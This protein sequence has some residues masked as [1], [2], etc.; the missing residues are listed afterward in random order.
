[1]I[2]KW[3]KGDVFVMEG[4]GASHFADAQ[5]WP[6]KTY[7]PGEGRGPIGKVVVTARGASLSPSP[8]GAPAFVGVVT[9]AGVVSFAGEVSFG[10]GA[11]FA[12]TASFA[13]GVFDMLG[14]GA[15]TLSGSCANRS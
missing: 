8:D 2:D 6:A 4:S 15:H 1:M 9:L 14:Y 12:Q 5:E 13:R 7:H 11:S 3:S 10:R